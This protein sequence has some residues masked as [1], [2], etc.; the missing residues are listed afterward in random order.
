MSRVRYVFARIGPPLFCLACAAWYLQKNVWRVIPMLQLPSDL[1]IYLDAGRSVLH[2]ETP[3]TV[4]G[5]IYPPLFA[6]FMAPLGPLDYGVARWIWFAVSHACLVGA[7]VVMWRALGRDWT[8]A[9]V[10]SLVWACGDAAFEVLYMGQIGPLLTLLLAVAYAYSGWRRESALGLG[11]ALKLI[12]AAAAIALVQVR[13]RRALAR[14]IGVAAV[15]IIACIVV[16]WLAVLTF[17]GPQRPPSIPF[18]GG[19]PA[20]LNWSV[21]PSVLRLMDSPKLGEDIPPN[22]GPAGTDLP[23]LDLPASHARAS[24]LAAIVTFGAGVLVFFVVSRGGLSARQL[25]LAMAGLMALGLAA[26]PIGWTHYQ[27]MQYPAVALLLNHAGRLRNWLLVAETL[28]CGACL[29]PLPVAM[30][31]IYYYS[32]EGGN[33]SPAAP[34][35]LHFWTSMTPAASLVLFA[36]LMR[37]VRNTKYPTSEVR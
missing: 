1:Q 37:E 2:G 4:Y 30:L 17:V 13:D 22:W 20:F 9:C 16:P 32:R 29:Y 25:P 28:L 8:A 31:T 24:A 3:F 35:T 23:K 19:T 36:L 14:M 33:W 7:A 12:P 11:I 10:V 18:L 6:F 15:C 27:V 26:C 34:G 21:P 5:Y